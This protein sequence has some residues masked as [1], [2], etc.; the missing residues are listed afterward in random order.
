MYEV[1]STL[2]RENASG[3]TGDS[4]VLDTTETWNTIYYNPVWGKDP[5]FEG[6]EVPKALNTGL[7]Y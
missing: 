1:C 3:Y 2:S 4:A 7:F 6:L 5:W